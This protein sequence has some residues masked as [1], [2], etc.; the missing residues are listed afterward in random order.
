MPAEYVQYQEKYNGIDTLLDKNSTIIHTLHNDL[1]GSF[2]T[3]GRSTAFSSEPFLRMIIV[4]AIERLSLRDTIVRIADSDFLRNFTRLYSG[5]M[6]G[7]ITL[8][9]AVKRITPS[10]WDTINPTSTI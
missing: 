6:P 1:A 3:D 10:T 2:S 5:A 9:T 7:F 4:K 8:Q